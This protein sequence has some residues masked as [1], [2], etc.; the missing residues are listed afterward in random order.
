[1]VSDG[2]RATRTPTLILA[3]VGIVGFV[4]YAFGRHPSRE[5][6]SA[7]KTA[8]NKASD[9]IVVTHTPFVTSAP[10]PSASARPDAGA[11]GRAGTRSTSFA[12][13]LQV[14]AGETVDDA[15]AH[16]TAGALAAKLEALGPS[17]GFRLGKVDCRTAMCTA[18]LEFASHSAAQANFAGVLHARSPVP[19]GVELQL[20]PDQRNTVATVVFR[21]ERRSP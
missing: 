1:M 10:P 18:A 9:D 19:C 6:P 4:G 14:H 3:G 13:A 16:T 7:S 21:C 17:L 20:A 15:W 2:Q 8:Y 11:N 5:T 12:D